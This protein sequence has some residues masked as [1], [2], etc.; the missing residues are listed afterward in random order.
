GGRRPPQRHGQGDRLGAS[1]RRAAVVRPCALRERPAVVRARAEGCGRRRAASRG[2]RRSFEPGCRARAR[3]RTDALRLRPRRPLQRVQ[4]AGA[5][6]DL[7][8][9]LLVG[10]ASSR[11]GPPKALARYEGETLAERGWRTLG[12]A[13]GH[14]LGVGKAGDGLELPFPLLDDG[15]ELRAP[16]V[17]LAA[18]V[19][20]APTR[21]RGLPPG[22]R[23]PG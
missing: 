15:S 20:P 4:R 16:I 12:T 19:A 11:F 3:P 8:G 22:G 21:L 23:P 17:G 2:R 5:R 18:G 1:R 7:T 14:R 10:G 6:G 9:I 13:C